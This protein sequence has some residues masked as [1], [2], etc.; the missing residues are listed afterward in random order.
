LKP[1]VSILIPAYNAQ[2][3]ITDT[4]HS[5]LSQTWERKEIVIVNDGSKDGT[6]DVL[7]KFESD[8]VRVY[9][10]E[11]QGA[12]AARNKAFSLCKGDYVQWLDA[13]DLLG[14]DKISSQM[15]V[16]EK[17][18][19][20]RT[21]VTGSWG[22][23]LYRPYRATF[24]PTSLWCDLSPVDWLVRKMGQNLFLQTA[25]W[26]VSRE[27]T[28]NAGPWDTQLLGDDDGEYFCRV[29]MGSDFIKFVPESKVYYRASGT[30]SLSYIGTSDRKMVAQWRSMQLHV[31]YIRSLED[32]PRIRE[33]CV[34]YLQNWLVFFYPQRPDLVEKAREL[35]QELGG[36]IQI[37]RLSWKYSWI[38]S[39]FGWPLANRVQILLPRLRW[40]AQRGWDKALLRIENKK[41]IQ[42]DSVQQTH[43]V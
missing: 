4:I 28:E 22:R 20:K 11:N 13:D 27:L 6:L 19:N 26:L 10:Q 23:F 40:S 39:L 17:N 15:A 21:L 8:T 32:S 2:E 41:L 12:A 29:L 9:S 38:K 3:W 35:A 7:K 34:K 42:S 36:D 30:T 37:P 1:L 14:P 5:A 18:G 16:L 33:A 24:V 43:S 31:K 25:N